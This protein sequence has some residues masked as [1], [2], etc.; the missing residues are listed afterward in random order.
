VRESVDSTKATNTSVLAPN[1][2]VHD[3][4]FLFFFFLIRRNVF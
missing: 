2:A 4:F 1:G 3:S